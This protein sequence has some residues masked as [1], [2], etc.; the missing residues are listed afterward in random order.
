MRVADFGI[1]TLMGQTESQGFYGTPAYM[2]PERK[3]Y[4][5][6]DSSADIYSAGVMLHELL[7]G[8]VPLVDADSAVQISDHLPE[9]VRTVLENLMS[10][11]PKNRPQAAQAV[12]QV[13]AL[14]K[15]YQDAD[16]FE[17][18]ERASENQSTGGRQRT[19]IRGGEHAPAQAASDNYSTQVPELGEA[20]HQTIIRPVTEAPVVEEEEIDE[21]FENE[22][23]RTVASQL[24]RPLVWGSILGILALICACVFVFINSSGEKKQE[25]PKEHWTAS[26]GTNSP[27]PSGLG[28]RLEA[29]YDPSS[30]TATVKFEYSTQKSG[31][32]GDILQVIPG[33]STDSCP[34]TTW[35]Q[36]SEAEEIRKNQA[37]IT[38]LDTKCAW[39]VSNLKI[40]ANS[41]VT[42]SAKV[43]IDIPDQKSL[44]KWL[45]E[46]TKK[47]QT[48]ISDPDVKSA[49]YPIQRIQ[50]IEVQ[51]PN[52]VVNQSAV[53]VTLLPVWPSGKDDLNPLMKLPQTGTP[54]QA[55]TSLAPDTG[56][57]AFTDG[58]SGHLSISADQK[59]V[60]ALSV[61]PQCKLN[62]Q[63]GN[64]TNLQSNAFSIT[65][66]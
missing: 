65:S 25:G 60:T 18:E 29:D 62:V 51:V 22:Q 36:A 31:L 61:A 8:A 52:R 28:T 5:S 45:G 40:P 30:H 11:S 47:T 4:G 64:F 35:N 56:D 41:A 63:V 19:V 50:K 55:I 57:I 24:K 27:L 37:A 20:S 16:R 54:S 59:N 43:D 46:I 39:N 32:H 1:A 14:R 26:S 33:L 17:Y 38:G 3:A 34:Q 2:S 12:A 66:R 48:A 7:V 9:D 53:P 13:R 49:S 15:K 6:S 44:E 23:P 10:L 42:M 58:C 21:E